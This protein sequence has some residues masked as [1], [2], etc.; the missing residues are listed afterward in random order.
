MKA[1]LLR[2]TLLAAL[3]IGLAVPVLSPFAQDSTEPPPPKSSPV[4]RV[5]EESLPRAG[6]I[7]V[8]GGSR[9]VGLEVVK[10]LLTRK[11]KVTVL[12][13]ASSDTTALKALD[14]SIITGD[15]LDPESLKQAF[16]SAP[17]RAVVSVLGGH[18]GDY[19]VDIEGN[20]NVADATKGAG[21]TRL[22]LVTAVGAGDSAEAAPWYV[23]WFLK[24]Y[25]AAKT[26]AEDY[27][28]ATDLD[29][30]D[31]RP[32][33]LFDS[34]T[35]GETGLIPGPAHFSAITRA[36][37]GKLLAGIIEDK[38]TYKK[39]FTAFDAKRGSLWAILTY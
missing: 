3:V 35:S 10:Q 12:V 25:Y 39:I 2:Y 17:F 1:A 36:D 32:G 7:M 34:E 6:G 18:G 21:I 28:R 11:E 24:D 31:V 38:S 16:T 37:L 26:A 15:A 33:L 22:I 4:I 8:F 9:G 14:A 19:R 30:T 27:L 23:R 29:Y 13:R 20:K 5:T